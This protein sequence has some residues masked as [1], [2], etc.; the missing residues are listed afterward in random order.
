MIHMLRN[1]M[2]KLDHMREQMS[3]VSQDKNSKNKSNGKGRN[4]EKKIPP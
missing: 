2:E 3:E 4:K 1:L